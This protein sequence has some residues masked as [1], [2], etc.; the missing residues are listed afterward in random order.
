MA[1][2]TIT[3]VD[4]ED[5][6]FMISTEFEPRLPRHDDVEEGYNAMTTAQKM[7]CYAV[8]SVTEVIEGTGGKAEFRGP[9]N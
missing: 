1:K 5:G 8:A 9:S 3:L 2:V 6:K 7:G 4:L